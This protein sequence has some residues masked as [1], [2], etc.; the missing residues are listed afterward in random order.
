MDDQ[1]RENDSSEGEPE[2][3][4]RGRQM[5]EWQVADIIENHDIADH[6]EEPETRPERELRQPYNLPPVPQLEPC[7][8]PQPRHDRVLHLPAWFSGYYDPIHN[9]NPKPALR[10]LDFFMLFFEKGTF[11][12]LANNTNLYAR[13]KGAGSEGHRRWYPMKGAEVMIF[14]GLIIYMGIYRSSSV[15]DYWRKDGLAPLH[16]YIFPYLFLKI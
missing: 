7:Q 11:E 3:E 13:E 16:K 12:T 10:P 1:D 8:H 6:E 4:G 9:P 5:G 15:L 14:V 2:F